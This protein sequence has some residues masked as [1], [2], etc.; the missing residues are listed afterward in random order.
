MDVGEVELNFPHI[1][2]EPGH[3]AAAHFEL[4]KY[5]RRRDIRYWRQDVADSLELA[6]KTG[7]GASWLAAE[8]S[9]NLS[10]NSLAPVALARP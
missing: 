2:I 7:P 1:R 5:S 10:A 3:P 4:S 8:D 9:V 6:L